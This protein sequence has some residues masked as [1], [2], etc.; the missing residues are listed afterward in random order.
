MKKLTEAQIDAILTNK[1]KVANVW[2]G[3]E[4]SIP[5]ILLVEDNKNPIF[6]VS[7][8]QVYAQF[9]VPQKNGARTLKALLDKDLTVPQKVKTEVNDRKL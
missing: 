3:S 9:E 2:F 1:L 8:P 4:L 6:G 5:G 7:F